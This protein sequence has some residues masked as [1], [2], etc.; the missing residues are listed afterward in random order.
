ML[1][2]AV[3]TMTVTDE[4][5]M[6]LEAAAAFLRPVERHKQSVADQFA[7]S[8]GN[9]AV[10]PGQGTEQVTLKLFGRHRRCVAVMGGQQRDHLVEFGQIGLARA[11]NDDDGRSWQGKGA[12]FGHFLVLRFYWCRQDA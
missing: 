9:E 4:K 11:A 1:T 6:Q 7:I 8:F 3:A 12:I 5:M 10:D 2:G